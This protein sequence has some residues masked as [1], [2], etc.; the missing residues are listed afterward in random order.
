MKKIPLVFLILPALIYGCRA[1]RTLS[2]SQPLMEKTESVAQPV[3]FHDASTFLLGYFTRQMMT[4]PPHSEW[5]QKG[6]DNYKF[7]EDAVKKLTEIPIKG[8]TIKI[9]MGSWC[10]DSR[11]EVPR[12]MK[13]LDYLKFPAENIIFIGVNDSKIAPVGEYSKLNIKRVPTFIF[14]KNN[15]EAGRIIENP[16]TSLEQDMVDILTR[17]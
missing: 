13:I 15:I 17:E 14:Y 5:F 2:E 3:D 7:N 6:Y 8:L 4:S 12:F 16:A 9:V 11:R 10:P 1:N